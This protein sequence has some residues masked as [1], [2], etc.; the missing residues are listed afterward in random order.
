MLA[1]GGENLID[2]VQIDTSEGLPLFKAIP[3]GSPFNVA[4]AAGRQGLG[5]RYLTPISTDASG[6]LLARRLTESAVEIAA[7]RNEA[8]SSLAMVTL[9]DGIPN[10]SFYRENTAERHITSDLLNRLLDQDIKILHLGSL[11]LAGGDD[12]QLWEETAL[13]ARARGMLFSLDP[14]VRAALIK[15]IP[16]YKQRIERLM[17][18]ADIV[19]LSDEDLFWL[20]GSEDETQA[21]SWLEDRTE[22]SVLILTRGGDGCQVYHQNVWH[23]QPAA[24]VEG[25]RDTV[26]AGDT[27]MASMIVWLS[28]HDFIDRLDALT[29][30][31][32][33]AMASYAAQAAALNCAHHG[34]HPPRRN[35]DRS[36]WSDAD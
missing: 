12:S 9:T 33:A 6:E 29:D 24:E 11:A 17:A 18:R 25:F 16:A 4:M 10:Y 36:G 22:A 1:V 14:N 7:P 34:C 20:C 31:D 19:K 15:D 30:K 5:V 13:A 23:H 26:G 27:F 21:L 28:D 8:P 35:H 32:K 2:L 3:G